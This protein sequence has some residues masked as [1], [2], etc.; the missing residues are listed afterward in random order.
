MIFEKVGIKVKI[1]I[2]HINKGCDELKSIFW[3]FLEI[4]S[5]AIFFF[6]SELFMIKVRLS[7]DKGRVSR[8]S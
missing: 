7:K 4:K 1:L 5:K 6:V 3:E 2:F 8:L